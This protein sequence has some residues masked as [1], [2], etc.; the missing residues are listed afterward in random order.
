ML[1]ETSLEKPLPTKLSICIADG[2]VAVVDVHYSWQPEF[3]TS[4]HSFGHMKDSC[5]VKIVGSP[6]P[7]SDLI[8]LTRLSVLKWVS[9]NIRL[10][11][12]LSPFE[13]ILSVKHMGGDE[14]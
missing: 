11:I 14:E 9:K 1:I 2:Q 13:I 4:C 3:C 7:F 5:K 12:V 10:A 6:L 8:P